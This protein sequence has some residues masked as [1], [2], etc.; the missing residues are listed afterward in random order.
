MKWKIKA[1]VAAAAFAAAAPASAAITDSFSGFQG[2]ELFFT[3]IDTA[4]ERSYTRDLGIETLAFNGSAPLSFAADST[5]SSFIAGT[6]SPANLIWNIGAAF[7][8]FAD[9]IVVLTTAAA[10]PGASGSAPTLVNSDLALLPGSQDLF[11]AA[12]NALGDH[13]SVTNGSNVDTK[14]ADPDGWGGGAYW[15]VSWGGTANFLT[16][17]LIGQSNSFFMLTQTS[18]PFD[19]VARSLWTE[20]GGNWT[21]AS[22]GNL[23]YDVAAV[24]VPAAVWLLGSGLFGLVGVARRRKLQAA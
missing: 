8:N 3:V 13:P 6:A 9:P 5:L 21:L 17:A 20:F 1:L 19:S 12:Q 23:T 4:G 15:G 16:T 18:D 24:P 10:M 7:N 14:A 22:N 11:L 2:A